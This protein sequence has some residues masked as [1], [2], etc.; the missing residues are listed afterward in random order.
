[1]AESPTDG[2]YPGFIGP[3]S[4]D[5]MA[6]LI[7]ESRVGIPWRFFQGVIDKY[8]EEGLRF[9]V[10][11]YSLADAACDGADGHLFYSVSDEFA[12][13]NGPLDGRSIHCIALRVP[14]YVTC[15]PSCEPRDG[16]H[17]ECGGDSA[18]APGIYDNLSE[19]D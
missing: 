19:E 2:E 12:C 14:D 9:F 15:T 1:I 6:S 16:D 13:D 10:L 7:A 11:V 5:H 8:Y 3:K 18:N 4:S 17:E